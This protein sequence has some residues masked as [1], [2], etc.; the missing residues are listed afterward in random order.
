MKSSE[1]LKLKKTIEQPI[2]GLKDF[3]ADLFVTTWVKAGPVQLK[4]G[5]TDLVTVFNVY[6]PGMAYILKKFLQTRKA[7]L[8]SIFPDDNKISSDEYCKNVALPLAYAL[9]Y[10][11]TPISK[12]ILAARDMFVHKQ[13]AGAVN[14]NYFLEQERQLK[15]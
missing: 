11:D 2:E 10:P 14:I 8:V 13:K 6:Q 3:N 7:T 5:D 4:M 9:L 1:Q 15:K 12:R